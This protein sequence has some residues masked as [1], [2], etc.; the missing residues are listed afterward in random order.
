MRSSAATGYG[1][2]A[3]IGDMLVTR[4]V[5]PADVPPHTK[6]AIEAHLT[7]VFTALAVARE[8]QTRTGLAIR[9]VTRQ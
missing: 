8:V 6:D 9:N 5:C 3:R 1:T 4:P 7:I 2:A